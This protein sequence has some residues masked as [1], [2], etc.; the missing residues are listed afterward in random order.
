MLLKKLLGHEDLEKKVVEDM[1][2]HI[3]LLCS[4]CESFH[5]AIEREDPK[6]MGRVKDL[7]RE[8][9]VIR[10]EIISSIYKGAFLP[11]L[12]PE[13]CKFVEIVDRVFDLLEYA[14]VCYIQGGLPEVLKAESMRVAFLNR[15]ICDMLRITFKATMDGDDLREKR[16]AIRLYEKRIDDMK[17]G[18]MQDVRQ[19]P[20][21]DFWEGT[22]LSEFLAR[23]CSISDM[24]EDA[25][26]H[27]GIIGSL[28]R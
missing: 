22:L 12:R 18:L 20:V 17:F 8:A 27:L 4:G 5:E 21:A 14:A 25:S 6:G 26:D 15:Q 24:I 1:E 10:R 2:R 16:L 13:L 9:D 19:V 3:V 11:Y 7:E 28:M 23:L